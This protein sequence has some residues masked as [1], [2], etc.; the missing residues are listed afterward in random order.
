MKPLFRLPP[1]NREGWAALTSNLQVDNG[2][3]I[4]GDFRVEGLGWFRGFTVKGFCVGL[5]L[6]FGA[7]VLRICGLFGK[8]FGGFRGTWKTLSHFEL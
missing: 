4:E 3:V 2:L 7:V 6:G 1:W 8:H 5:S